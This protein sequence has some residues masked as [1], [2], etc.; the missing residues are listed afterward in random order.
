MVL[1][2]KENIA[3]VSNEAIPKIQLYGDLFT[4]ISIPPPLPLKMVS[5]SSVNKPVTGTQNLQ[6][7]VIANMKQ[8]F[9]SYKQILLTLII[10]L[11]LLAFG[12]CGCSHHLRCI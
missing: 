2:G 1:F 4:A 7:I 3:V 8:R 12:K 9:Y 11:I 10:F 5:G 6:D